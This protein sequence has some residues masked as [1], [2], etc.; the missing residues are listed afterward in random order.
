M[1]S[2]L[3]RVERQRARGGARL[4]N[5]ALPPYCAG[6]WHRCDDGRRIVALGCGNMLPMQSNWP[7]TTAAWVPGEA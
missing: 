1:V 7:S 5:S 6:N 2:I 4:R 3:S